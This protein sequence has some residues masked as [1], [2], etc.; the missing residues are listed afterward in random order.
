MLVFWTLRRAP[1]AICLPVSQ[2]AQSPAN[3]LE[4]QLPSRYLATFHAR[5]VGTA[6]TNVS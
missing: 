6:W 5:L 1:E 3:Q 2:Q 4:Q